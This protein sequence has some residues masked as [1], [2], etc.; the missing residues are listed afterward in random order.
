MKAEILLS[1]LKK[2]I[3]ATK[4]FVGS[5][6]KNNHL[7]EYVKI[8]VIDGK[9]I[10]IALDGHRISKETVSCNAD[11]NFSCLIKP[12]IPKYGYG[13]YAEIELSGNYAYISYG[14]S[15]IGFKQPEGEYYKINTMMD[16][17]NFK[18]Y[19]IGFDSK[20][21]KEALESMEGK[22]VLRFG[23]PK[24]PVLICNT[25]DEVKQERLVLPIS[26]RPDMY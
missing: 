20:L 7:M 6:F 13:N 2:I 22:V 5:E 3:K 17:E 14:D 4:K 11:Q 9:M 18:K 26:L 25:G 10:A 1:D 21:L 8:K 12:V 24:D 23:E 16:A 19:T 15:R